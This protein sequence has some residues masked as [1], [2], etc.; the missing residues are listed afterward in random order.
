VSAGMRFVKRMRDVTSDDDTRRWF[1]LVVLLAVALSVPSLSRAFY[2]RGEPREALV[3]QSMLLSGNWVSPP[4]YNGAV[5]SKPPFSHWLIAIASLPSARVT[6][7]TARLPSALGYVLFAAGY[8]V[9]LRRRAGPIVA[10]MASLILLS[11]PEW[12][13]SGTTC[14]VDTLLAVCIS[15]ALL[16]LFSWNERQRR[17]FPLLALILLSG[18]A[19]TKGPVGIVL[20][21]GVFSLFRMTQEPFGVRSWSRIIAQSVALAALPITAALTWYLAGY[22]E[23]GDAFVEKIWYENVARLTSSMDDEPHKHSLFYLLGMLFVMLLPWSLAWLVAAVRRRSAGKWTLWSILINLTSLQMFSLI[24]TV[25]IVGFFCIPSSKRSVY[26]L[27]AYPFIAIIAASFVDAWLAR[28]SRM[29]FVLARILLGL[30]AVL[31]LGAIAVLCLPFSVAT[32]KFGHSL[33]MAT[34]FGKILLTIFLVLATWYLSSSIRRKS[35][36]ANVALLIV[37]LAA[38]AGPT[39]VDAGMW[40]SSP[41]EWLSSQEFVN[42]VRP[43][44][45]ERF[46]SFGSEQYA[47]SFYLE[48]PFFGANAEIAPHSIV[49]MEQRNLARF[50]EELHFQYRELSRYSSGFDPRKDP[51]VVEIL[52]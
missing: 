44:E 23:R 38:V 14:R 17:G 29:M 5:P 22:L 21:L 12:L 32:E 45:H 46:Y 27:P 31:P 34:G 42:A 26:L 43:S 52:P 25:S 8:F 4:A 50:S 35:V 9:F 39:V 20:P 28:T 3:A 33:L 2:T 1:W 36:V 11:S 13:R 41:K 37:W 16:S 48:K 49:F 15:G 10:L 30:L 7:V 47:A 24:A 19:L 18:A 6:E 51:V 40:Q